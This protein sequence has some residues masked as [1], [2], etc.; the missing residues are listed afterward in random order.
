[1]RAESRGPFD[2]E[3][4]QIH[5][6]AKEIS[7]IGAVVVATGLTRIFKERIQSFTQPLVRIPLVGK[8]GSSALLVVSAL[9]VTLGNYVIKKIVKDLKAKR[10]ES[11]YEQVS[12]S[13]LNEV[14]NQ[15][16]RLSVA[17][18]CIIIHSIEFFFSNR[19]PVEQGSRPLS[20][21][22][23]VELMGLVS[24]GSLIMISVY[25]ILK[26]KPPE[27][28]PKKPIKPTAMVIEDISSGENQRSNDSDPSQLRPW[29][30]KRQEIRNGS[31]SKPSERDLYN[32]PASSE[33]ASK[34][35]W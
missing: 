12:I 21:L 22:N 23:I 3:F 28:P 9:C 13:E 33:P 18:F 14:D 24:T 5:L 4:V 31:T 1:M 15:V 34:E 7:V 16:H 29:A 20:F 35:E 8:L 32:E 27:D 11:I 17:T 6:I 26:I 25:N 10:N 30:K 19:L 2:A